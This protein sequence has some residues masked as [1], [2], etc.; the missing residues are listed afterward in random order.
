MAALYMGTINYQLRK[1]EEAQAFYLEAATEVEKTSDFKLGYLIM[2][3]LGNLYL[4]RNLP[5]EQRMSMQSKP[6]INAMK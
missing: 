5:D 2:S 3:G 1:A 4:F 6:L